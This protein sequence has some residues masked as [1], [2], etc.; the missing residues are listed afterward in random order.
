[1]EPQQPMAIMVLPS[2]PSIKLGVQVD[3][4]EGQEGVWALDV[5]QLGLALI[6]EDQFVF[7]PRQMV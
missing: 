4:A 7:L 2:Q 5:L 1:M 3:Q 6:L